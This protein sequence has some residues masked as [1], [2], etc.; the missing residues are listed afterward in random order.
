[1]VPTVALHLGAV[2]WTGR[3]GSPL[4][5]PGALQK[6]PPLSGQGPQICWA[7]GVTRAPSKALVV[8]GRKEKGAR[9]KRACSSKKATL[10]GMLGLRAAS[11]PPFTPQIIAFSKLPQPFL[12]PNLQFL[13]KQGVVL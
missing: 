2:G 3:L 13:R 8:T 7:R 11:A 12:N 5:L 4:K 1:M 6:V 10:W 9:E